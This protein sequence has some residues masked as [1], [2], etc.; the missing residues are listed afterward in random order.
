MCALTYAG[1]SRLAGKQ[2]SRVILYYHGVDERCVEN[3]RQQMAYLARECS[4]VKAC[5]IH[6]MNSEGSKT[7]VAITF[8]D[9]F[10]SVLKNAVPILR[11]YGL[12]AAIFVPTGYIGQNPGWAMANDC[13]DKS[14]TVMTERQIAELDKE[15][16]EI[17]SHTVTHA[18]L[19]DLNDA[20]L[21][22]ELNQS[23][24][25]LEQILGHNVTAVSYPHGACNARIHEA[26]QRAGYTMGFTISPEVVDHCPDP[27]CIGRFKTLPDDRLAVF[28][29]KATGAYQA[30]RT[31]MNLKRLVKHT[32]QRN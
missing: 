2:R 5:D 22:T 18:K 12:P 6:D 24:Q 4:V 31:L 10:V 25:R 3:F 17:L 28:K 9:A 26:A 27:L 15:G 16:F 20:D 19:T 14:E 23:K 1:V 11:E 7:V 30:A 32:N 29:L 13:P 21:E 8:D